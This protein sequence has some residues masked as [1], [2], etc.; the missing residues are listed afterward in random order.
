MKKV[1]CLA[2][3]ALVQNA[4]YF[5]LLVLILSCDNKKTNQKVVAGEITPVA[6]KSAQKKDSV[7]SVSNVKR[8]LSF[9]A[10]D[11]LKGR[12]SGSE[13]LQKAADFIKDEFYAYGVAPYKKTFLDTFVAHKDTTFNVIGFLSGSDPTLSDEIIIIGA[14]YDHIGKAKIVN[15]DT[16]ANGANDNASG[17]TA[18]LL[19]A[20]YF[21]EQKS[22]KRSIL[23]TL[24]SA[25][26]RGLLGSKDLAQ[27]LQK[28][29]KDIYLMLNFEMIGVPLKNKDYEAY[30]TGYETSN[31]AEKLNEYSNNEKLIGF[32]PEAKKFNLFKRSDNFPIYEAL[33]I[34]SQTISTFDFTNYPYY[35]HVDDESSQMDFTFI[36]GFTRKLIPS[37]EALVT[38]VEK[39]VKLISN[40][41]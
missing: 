41:K 34:P 27:K 31:F 39:E 28:E 23:F 36:A 1:H 13:G 35:H 4:A 38:T 21:A 7:F 11:S 6:V 3:N 37:I 30:I 10:S 26:E 8:I 25:E 5:V 40:D 2:K 15:K 32:L 17:T 16:I 14:H 9:L 12:E 29:N 22:N 33:K 18:V 19:L 20:N 24:F